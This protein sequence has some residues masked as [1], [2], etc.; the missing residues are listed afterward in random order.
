ML[1]SIISNA[2]PRDEEKERWRALASKGLEAL[3]EEVFSWKIDPEIALGAFYTAWDVPKGVATTAAPKA[4]SGAWRSWMYVDAQDFASPK[5]LL[6]YCDLEWCQGVLFDL[7]RGEF[8]G[9]KLFLEKIQSKGLLL[10]YRLSTSR[11]DSKKNPHPERIKNT[12]ASLPKPSFVWEASCKTDPLSSVP[13]ACLDNTAFQAL[14]AS[15]SLQLAH[16]LGAALV[17]LLEARKKNLDLQQALSSW[18]IIQMA[19][20]DY[21]HEIAKL[22][23]LRRCL[24]KLGTALGF[25]DPQGAAWQVSIV[26]TTNLW[27]ATH[28]DPSMALVRA[29]SQALASVV[30][31]ATDLMPLFPPEGARLGGAAPQRRALSILQILSHEANL[32]HPQDPAH[33]SYFFEHLTDALGRQGWKHF[34]QVEQL[35]GLGNPT[36]RK[37]LQ[38]AACKQGQ[39]LEERLRQRKQKLIGLNAYVQP[40]V[41]STFPCPPPK[42]KHAFVHAYDRIGA[43]YEALVLRYQSRATALKDLVV[44]VYASPEAQGL[45]SYWQDMVAAAL[46]KSLPKR[47]LGLSAP[48]PEEKK[49][50]L[51]YSLPP[52]ED[53]T[54]GVPV[55]LQSLKRRGPWPVLCYASSGEVGADKKKKKE[56]ASAWKALGG[57]G[58]DFPQAATLD[59]WQRLQQIVF[60]ALDL[61]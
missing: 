31:G 58:F 24:A 19:E 7:G 28:I 33:G 34:Q 3:P 29:S 61:A 38:T 46:G 22:R 15:P 8:L 1:M 9:G 14:G 57:H 10:A 13:T 35:G 26:S 48:L 30:G 44:A 43:A 39:H 51:L 17:Y 16:V 18:R 11:E 6:P 32:S 52:D 47:S 25:A 20:A 55:R 49:L 2:A 42:D 36:A 53:N 21:F 12:W 59:G 27:Q 45:Q 5:A 23:A 37:Y 56:E 41:P 4:P 50:L 60:D 54:A 40:E